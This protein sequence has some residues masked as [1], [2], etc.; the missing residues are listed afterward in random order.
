MKY[1]VKRNK[2]YILHLH[3]KSNAE[4]FLLLLQII[5]IT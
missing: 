5:T 1:T 4:N 3:T 2:L